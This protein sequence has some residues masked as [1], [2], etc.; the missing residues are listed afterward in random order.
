[1]AKD[2]CKNCGD[3]TNFGN[4]TGPRAK[5]EWCAACYRTARAA[6]KSQPGSGPPIW[7]DGSEPKE[8]R[9]RSI[10][11]RTPFDGGRNAK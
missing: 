2:T 6:A 7:V 9:P 10:V 11:R 1:V 4:A 8:D 5:L 3:P